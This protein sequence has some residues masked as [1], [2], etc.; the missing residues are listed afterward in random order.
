MSQDPKF[1]Y[2]CCF[3]A[4]PIIET[5][6]DPC[7]LIIVVDWKHDKDDADNDQQFFTHAQCFV[8][9]LHETMKSM[10]RPEIEHLLGGPAP[11]YVAEAELNENEGGLDASEGGEPQSSNGHNHQP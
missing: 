6:V 7:A 10:L 8:D 5:S 1:L 11:D 2:G 4:Q 9:R 3:C